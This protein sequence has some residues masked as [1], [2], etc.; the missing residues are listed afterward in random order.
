MC[1]KYQHAVL[2]KATFWSHIT[3]VADICII[4]AEGLPRGGVLDLEICSSHYATVGLVVY[5][6]ISGEPWLTSSPKFSSSTCS[7]TEFLGISGMGFYGARFP[8]GHP[9]NSVK[10]IK[11]IHLT[12]DL[13]LSFLHTPPNPG[14]KRCQTFMPPYYINTT[15]F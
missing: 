9:T 7:G 15:H 8:S 3:V 4:F 10:A 12:N 13:V 14:G 2:Q 11:V 6:G 5:S 1:H